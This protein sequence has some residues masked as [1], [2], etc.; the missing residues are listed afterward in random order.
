M[1]RTVHA[2]FAAFALLL[3]AGLAV[4]TADARQAAPIETRAAALKGSSWIWEPERSREGP[5]EVVIG[6]KRQIAFVYRGGKLIGAS[7]ISSGARGHES[8]IGRFQILEKKRHHRSN[9]YDDAPMP[10][11]QRLNWY[12]VAL[13]GGHVNGRPLSKGCIRLPMGFAER[14][15]GATAMGGFVFITEDEL[16]SPAAALELARAHADA[17]IPADRMPRNA[18][19]ATAAP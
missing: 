19:A 6:L 14:L 15:F 3:V 9:R 4:P 8:P 11:M 2:L 17:P 7:S 10:F 16:P 12:G 18:A 13:H 5:V 1:T